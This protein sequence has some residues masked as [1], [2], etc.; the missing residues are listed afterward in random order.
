M[1]SQVRLYVNEPLFQG[2]KV[3]LDEKQHHYL[4]H[5]MR[6]Q[7]KEKL[8]LFNGKEGEWLAEISVLNKKQALLSVQSQTRRQDDEP[9]LDAWLCFAPIKKD[10]MDI[11]IEKATELG[12]SRL[13]PVITQR[14]VVSKISTEKMFLKLTEAA[15]QCER[16]SVPTIEKPCSLDTFLAQFPKDRTLFF[17]NERENGGILTG[18]ER[19]VAFLIG[20]EGGFTPAEM[21]KVS[22][23][24]F[25]KSI[26]FGRR[27]LRAETA[28][29]AALAAWNQVVGW[30]DK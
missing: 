12:V 23:F 8:L 27:I 24:P 11:V 30:K 19:P 18:P 4:Y 3:T 22:A 29:I 9:P 28:S 2:Q 5:V 7:E 1:A 20:P 21:Q 26:H 10:C 16:L 15:E 14:T 13:V 6:L 25:A 17:L